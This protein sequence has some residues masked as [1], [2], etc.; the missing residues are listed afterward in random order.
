MRVEENDFEIFQD[1]ISLKTR[2]KM[3]H[4]S[5]LGFLLEEKEYKSVSK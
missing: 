5:D 4:S 2:T 3:F 1:E